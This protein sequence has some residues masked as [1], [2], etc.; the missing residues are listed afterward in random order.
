L[1]R[2]RVED[3]VYGTLPD[4]ASLRTF[5]VSFDGDVVGKFIRM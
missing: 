3:A 1:H 2:K 4:E 5:A